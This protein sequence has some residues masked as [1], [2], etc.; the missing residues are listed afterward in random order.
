MHLLK[1]KKRLL[2]NERIMEEIPSEK[3]KKSK[4][5]VCAVLALGV[6]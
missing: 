4:M 2:P 5:F 6:S 1:G 3:K